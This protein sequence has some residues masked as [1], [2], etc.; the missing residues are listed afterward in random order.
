MGGVCDVRTESRKSKVK[1]Q[2]SKVTANGL[3]PCIFHLSLALLPVDSRDNPPGQ[4]QRQGSL[5]CNAREPPS[6]S[7][8]CFS[9]CWQPV[10]AR[11]HPSPRPR[12]C[13]L[14]HCPR[15]R[16]PRRHPPP[17]PPPPRPAR[18]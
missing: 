7:A 12:R 18:S 11:R 3:I 2:K 13:P 9:R 6:C 10:L 4:C 15:G 5:L 17:L 16:P 1:G 8:S 14:A